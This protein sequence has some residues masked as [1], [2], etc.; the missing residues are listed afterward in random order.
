VIVFDEAHNLE[1][2]ATDYLSVRLY[3]WRI[4]KIVNRLHR[5]RRD[6]TG[7]GLFTNIRHQLSMSKAAATP[8]AEAAEKR[9]Q[10]I[11][12]T[13]P[14][15][16]KAAESF[17]SAIGVLFE[18]RRQSTYSRGEDKLRFSAQSRR[19]DVWEDVEKEKKGL[20]AHLG[21]LAKSLEGLGEHV[22]ELA[23]AMSYGREFQRE[24]QFQVDQLK[25]L[26]TDVEFVIAGGEE[27]YVYWA[28]RSQGA[29]VQH[30]LWAAPLDISVM[31][32]ENFFNAKRTI[33]L[34]SAT[35]SVDGRF[36]FMLERIGAVG[37][38]PG[39]IV[40]KDVGS[41]F[42]FERQT[43]LC[44]PRFL[45]EPREAGGAFEEKLAELLV[46]MFMASNGRGM[47]LFTS[48]EM[49]DAV[50]PA[51]KERLEVENILVLGQGK[52]GSR[53]AITALFQ[54][55]ITSVLL[56]TQS[57]WEGVDF[58]GETLSLL[59]IAKLPFHVP[60]E[61]IVQARCELLESRGVDSF[62]HYTLPSAVIRLKQG[63]GRLIRTKTDRG[64]VVITD[65][66]LL[67]QRYGQAF[68][69]SLPTNHSAFA[70]KEGLL[71]AIQGFLGEKTA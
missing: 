39:R 24:I 33:V 2:V 61:P 54:R 46:E 48:Y 12:G 43:R 22:K 49:L 9:I 70:D 15:V 27:N 68:L 56:G 55:D 1:N 58:A 20:I 11:I 4:Y 44:I 16:G 37:L 29:R 32:K 63:F 40:C 25:E 51:V 50:H 62:L 31:M 26:I 65:R 38:P 23:D 35:L 64:I 19:P 71:E 8:T 36:D 45:P 57:F 67:T 7:K 6:G 42:D 34:S 3:G 17:F 13:L 60:T 41:S 14:E 66:R 53:E 59:V 52:D 47:A 10:R 28:A 69:R 18:M 21:G 5:A 30:E